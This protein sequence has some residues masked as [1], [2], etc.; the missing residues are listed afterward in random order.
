MTCLLIKIYASDKK[1]YKKNITSPHPPS[2]HG[3]VLFLKKKKKNTW[4]C[5]QK[6]DLTLCC[7]THRV[8]VPH[9]FHP[10]VI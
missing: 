8:T 7:L 6:S 9:V 5:P 1:K 4:H 3:I 2:K 10:K